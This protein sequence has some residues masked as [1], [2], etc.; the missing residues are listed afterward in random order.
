MKRESE[1][2]R[3]LGNDY[4]LGVSHVQESL[5][6]VL[7]KNYADSKV[8]FS[9]DNE[10]IMSSQTNTEEELYEFAKTHSKKDYNTIGNKVIAVSLIFI[11][12]ISI[13]NLFIGGKL[14]QFILTSDFW[15]LTWLLVNSKIYNHNWK[16][17]MLELN[18]NWQRVK[19][20]RAKK[21]EEIGSDK[22]ESRYVG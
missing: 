4:H 20:R 6:W 12:F 1:I 14:S 16:I 22:D 15:L 13:L 19:K 5:K 7:F 2:R 8:Y 11:Y 17:T 21:F 9:K 10:A 18:E 3:L